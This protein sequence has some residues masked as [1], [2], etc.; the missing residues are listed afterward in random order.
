[1][2]QASIALRAIRPTDQ[3]ALERKRLALAFGDEV[4]RHDHAVV[5]LQQRIVTAVKL[6]NSTVTDIHGVGPM[7]GYSGDVRRFPTAGHYARYNATAPIETSSGPRVRH[8]LNPTATANSTTRSISPRSAR[9]ATT[10]PA[11]PTTSPKQ[12]AG[13]SRKEPCAA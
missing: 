13:K 2:K 4:R 8:R 6:A 12:T 5:E 10:H 3:V 11:A 7:L 9:S 1:V